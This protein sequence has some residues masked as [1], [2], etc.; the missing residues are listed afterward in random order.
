MD[1]RLSKVFV[2]RHEPKLRAPESRISSMRVASSVTLVVFGVFTWQP[3]ANYCKIDQIKANEWGVLVSPAWRHHILM[4]DF[5]YVRALIVS[6]ESE[7]ANGVGA[8]AVIR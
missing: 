8:K 1:C 6:I 5:A 3:V 4:F 7:V 2:R